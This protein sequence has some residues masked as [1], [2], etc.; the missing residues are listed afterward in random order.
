MN[1]FPKTDQFDTVILMKTRLVCGF[2]GGRFVEGTRFLRASDKS[3]TSNG[4]WRLSL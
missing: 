1:E 2:F 4:G 3:N